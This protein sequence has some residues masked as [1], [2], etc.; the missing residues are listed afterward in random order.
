[1]ERR[2]RFAVRHANN[3]GLGQA[4]GEEV[5]EPRFV[6]CIERAGGFV[7]EQVVRLVEQDT[8]GGEALLFARRQ[9]ARP[10]SGVRETFNIVVEMTD[11]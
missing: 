7:E 5:I 3:R 11:A 6:G 9:N 4:L 1:V 8:G 2:E 10:V